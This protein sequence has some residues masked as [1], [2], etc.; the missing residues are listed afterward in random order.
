MQ[1]ARRIISGRAPAAPSSS[2]SADRL[3]IH[4]RIF[5]AAVDLD[6]ELESVAF[7]ERGD[8]RALHGGNVNKSV[9]L[10]IVTL[11]EAE[12]LH[13]VEEL[14]RPARLLACE[15]PLRATPA[16]GAALPASARAA[17]F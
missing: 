13:R 17:P 1:N 5:T 2:R 7:I 4:C 12:A 14:D 6:L 16:A 11:D 15:L 8:A 3:E 10:P 9:G